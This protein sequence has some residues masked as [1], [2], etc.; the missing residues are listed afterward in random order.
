MR[1]RHKILSRGPSKAYVLHSTVGVVTAVVVND[2]L[3]ASILPAELLSIIARKGRFVQFSLWVSVFS[4]AI[5]GDMISF[6]LVA[7]R[8]KCGSACGNALSVPCSGMRNN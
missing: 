8:V 6:S 5:W 1:N 2:I 4:L 7:V 3:P